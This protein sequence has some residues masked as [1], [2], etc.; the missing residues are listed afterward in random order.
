[1]SDPKKMDAL[2]EFFMSHSPGRRATVAGLVN[3]L[4]YVLWEEKKRAADLA[5]N[6][7][8]ASTA[9]RE[10]L[11]IEDIDNHVAELSME[12]E[13]LRALSQ[14]LVLVRSKGTLRR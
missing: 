7:E 2:T 11:L 5:D 12:M 14:A 8:A 6:V 3:A 1:M 9:S 10:D 13:Q 4:R